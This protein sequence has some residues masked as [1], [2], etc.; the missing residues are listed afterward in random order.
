MAV[1][2]EMVVTKLRGYCPHCFR[3]LI[4]ARNDAGLTPDPGDLALCRACGEGSIFI[5]TMGL[6]RPTPQERM[7]I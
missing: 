6:R 7:G 3:K 2:C 1:S 4:V 5:W